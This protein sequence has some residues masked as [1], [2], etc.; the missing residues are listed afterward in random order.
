MREAYTGAPASYG[1]ATL[2]APE[3]LAQAIADRDERPIGV[4]DSGVGGL[5]I[6]KELFREL[7]DERYVYFGDTGNCPYGV[8]P[9]AEIQRLALAAAHH[10]LERRA[11]II[12]VACNTASVAALKELRSAYAVP[13]VGV[14]PAVKPAAER[15][16]TN[17]IGIASTEASTRGDYLKHLIEEHASGVRSISVGCPRLVTLAEAGVLDGPEAEAAIREYIG[18][19]LAQNIDTLVLGCT[20]FP[21]MRAAFE[22]VAGPTVEIIDS[23]AAI[24]RQT[25]RIL[26]E[27]CAL[28]APGAHPTEAPRGPR[29]SDEFHCSGDAA[30]FSRVAGAILGEPV[31]ATCVS[32]MIANADPPHK[33]SDRVLPGFIPHSAGVSAPI[34]ERR[35]PEE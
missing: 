9:E 12:V 6:L 21:A 4:F 15:T 19:M 28:A 13:F 32:G 8:R 27:R 5:T 18:P 33:P 24:A 25:R 10:L 7:P 2:T 35:H 34:Q 14:V 22:R 30:N 20:H 23:G 3:P 16:R 17:V 11:K 29:A 26:E 31:T 1:S